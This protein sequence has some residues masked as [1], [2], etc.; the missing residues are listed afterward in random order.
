[1]R[2][3]KHAYESEIKQPFPYLKLSLKSEWLKQGS[4]KQI[5]YILCT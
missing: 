1:M 2:L 3:F 5:I 4:A